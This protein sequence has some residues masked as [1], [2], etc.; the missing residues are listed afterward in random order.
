MA[1]R[2][3]RPL[4]LPADAE[5]L[6]AI[7]ASVETG[8]TYAVAPIEWGFR[9]TAERLEHAVRKEFPIAELLD[10]GDWDAAFVAVSGESLVGV[11]A[12]SLEAW[13]RRLTIRHLY[14]HAPAR[15]AGIGR[16]LLE[17]ALAAGASSGAVS[18]WLETPNTNYPGIQAYL[19]MG[20]HVCGLDTALYAN[21][22]TSGEV[23][24]FLS[25]SIA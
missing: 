9:I 22:P 11:V 4:S 14:V 6:R 19:A 13:N 3:I 23:A 15:R 16:R 8:R 17:H 12:S 7:D 24:L 1:P 21:T 2:T 20:F 10:A 5:A 25:R 18:A